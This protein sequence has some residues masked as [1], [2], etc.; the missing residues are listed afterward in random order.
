MTEQVE[1]EADQSSG[2]LRKIMVM[3][4]LTVIGFLV[5]VALMGTGYLEGD[6]FFSTLLLFLLRLAGIEPPAA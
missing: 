2:R 4:Q 6:N 5:L 1:K 3:L